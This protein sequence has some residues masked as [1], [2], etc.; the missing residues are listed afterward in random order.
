MKKILV[1]SV[2]PV[3][4][5]GTLLG[6]QKMFPKDKFRIKAVAVN[7]G[8]ADQPLT[9]KETFQGALNRTRK[10]LRKYPDF[11]YY[12]GIEAG[13]EQ[14]RSELAA[15]AW[16]VIS[17]AGKMGNGKSAAF[18]LPPKAKELIDRGY[19]LGKVMDI[20]FRRKNTKLKKG[21]VGLLTGGIIDRARLYAEA[22]I[23]ALIPFKQQG[24][25]NQ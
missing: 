9:D 8:V 12:V 14:W 25:Y 16:V 23:L 3:K 15:F 21:A 13:V 11:N 19:E 2:N 17:C 1:T 18:F 24:L 7:S 5:R 6:F 10:A 20:I 22:V 4:I